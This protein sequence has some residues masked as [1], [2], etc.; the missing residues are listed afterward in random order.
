MQVPNLDL[1]YGVNTV[2]RC[3]TTRAS[4]ELGYCHS[5]FFWLRG[6][7]NN[8]RFGGGSL[9]YRGVFRD[10]HSGEFVF[11]VA[12]RIILGNIRSTNSK[13]LQQLCTSI[14]RSRWIE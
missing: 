5:V 6:D 2:R 1:A 7:G 13:V 8:S 10:S 9:L 4:G 12:V 3:F 11:I 14:V